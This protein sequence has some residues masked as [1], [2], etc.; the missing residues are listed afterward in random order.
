MPFNE[1]SVSCI[2]GQHR[3]IELKDTNYQMVCSAYQN[4]HFVNQ[5]Q[6]AVIVP[7][8]LSPGITPLDPDIKLLFGRK[9]IPRIDESS[10][11]NSLECF[12]SLSAIICMNKLH[13]ISRK[14]VSE[15]QAFE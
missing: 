3:V 12:P 13:T 8:N 1:L 11:E 14:G 9:L 2:K 15:G 6:S 7:C 5:S 10:F 4:S